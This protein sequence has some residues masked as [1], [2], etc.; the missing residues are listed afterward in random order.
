MHDP[1]GLDSLALHI[2]CRWAGR[3]IAYGQ[4]LG[5]TR[6][7]RLTSRMGWYWSVAGVGIG[8]VAP[9]LAPWLMSSPPGLSSVEVLPEG[10]FLVPDGVVEGGVPVWHR[11]PG[12]CVVDVPD[13]WK[14]V[15]CG[16][17]GEI[18]LRTLIASGRAAVRDG[19][20]MLEF[21]PGQQLSFAV[22]GFEFT[23]HLAP[24]A[25]RAAPE[26]LDRDDH[27]WVLTLTVVTTLAAV[28]VG[29]ALVWGS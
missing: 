10:D 23:S 18:P 6:E 29:T 13:T 22:G 5:T 8:W 28:V 20:V 4:F 25:P 26:V 1:G 11:V 19:R 9:R 2:G 21:G 17:G 3:P 15:L 7:V 16:A 27:A 24:P 12:G 14:P